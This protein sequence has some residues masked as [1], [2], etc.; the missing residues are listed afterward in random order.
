M[1]SLVESHKHQAENDDLE[2]ACLHIIA[3]ML[4]PKHQK[5]VVK[6]V[7]RIMDTSG[8][9]A[10]G[11]DEIMDGYKTIYGLDELDEETQ[12]K[13]K[14]GMEE[15]DKE[16][17]GYVSLS[18]FLVGTVDL[19]PAMFQTY[20]ERAYEKYFND[21]KKYFM[22]DK[23]EFMNV[24]CFEQVMKQ[25]LAES[26]FN[27][28]DQDKSNSISF[29]EFVAFFI[30]TLLIETDTEECVKKAKEKFGAL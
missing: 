9:G 1:S 4:I 29:E 28:I 11:L 17:V 5:L 26:F 23:M 3:N 8:D 19:S 6:E 10:L 20:V 27:H 24:I 21:P 18:Q 30:D 2:Q 13:L 15:I 25:R 16:K 12:A 22:M 14:N 7:F